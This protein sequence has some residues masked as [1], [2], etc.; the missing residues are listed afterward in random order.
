MTV[1]DKYFHRHK[2]LGSMKVY[3]ENPRAW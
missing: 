2:L 3:P 1:F